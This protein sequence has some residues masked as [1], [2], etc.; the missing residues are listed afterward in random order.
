MIQEKVEQE[1]A[2]S[3]AE[4]EAQMEFALSPKKKMF[5]RIGQPGSGLGPEDGAGIMISFLFFSLSVIL[6]FFS[7]LL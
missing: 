6:V 4:V 5:A 3:S 2:A 1:A 7:R